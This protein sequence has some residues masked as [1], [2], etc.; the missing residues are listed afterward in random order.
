MLIFLNITALP[1]TVL[2]NLSIVIL[3]LLDFFSLDSPTKIEDWSTRNYCQLKV[4]TALNFAY[5]IQNVYIM[6]GKDTFLKP[7]LITFFT[8]DFDIFTICLAIG[9]LYLI[10]S[11]QCFKFYKVRHMILTIKYRGKSRPVKV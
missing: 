8:Y 3:F 4:L 7:Y 5:N 9:R 1:I 6:L 2:F 11:N 10:L